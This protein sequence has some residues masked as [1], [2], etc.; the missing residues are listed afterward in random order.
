MTPARPYLLRAVY[1]W[2]V[3]NRLTPQLI[4]DSNSSAVQ[5]ICDPAEQGYVIL[6]ISPKAVCDLLMNNEC[7]SFGARF[8]GQAQEISVPVHAISAIFARENG[9]GMSFPSDES[10]SD[11]PPIPSPTKPKRP[12]LK[13][14]K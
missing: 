4:V 14:I 2:L 13:V 1:E 5:H 11:I 8:K 9:K 12:T 3:D 7:V 6:N 10:F